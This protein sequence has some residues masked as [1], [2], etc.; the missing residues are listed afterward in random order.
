[1]KKP[2][3]RIHPLY[4]ACR[5]QGLSGSEYDSETFLKVLGYVDVSLDQIVSALGTP[6]FGEPEGVAVVALTLERFLDSLEPREDFLTTLRVT[7][8]LLDDDELLGLVEGPD[9][10][11]LAEILPSFLHQPRPQLLQKAHQLHGN[12]KLLHPPPL[13]LAGVA[14]GS[15]A[16]IV[17][18]I[19]IREH[20]A[21]ME[22]EGLLPGGGVHLIR[23]VVGHPTDVLDHRL[24]LPPDQLVRHQVVE[25]DLLQTAE[26]DL[27]HLDDRRIRKLTFEAEHLAVYNAAI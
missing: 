9:I 14:P 16:G 11:R 2:G 6:T 3:S 10:V 4:R 13:A 24:D 12:A 1:M 27:G 18:L 19:A 20:V 26:L 23:D 22:L 5:R 15:V 25:T 8:H 21:E 7:A 17:T